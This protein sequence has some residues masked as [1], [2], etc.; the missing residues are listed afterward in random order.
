MNAASWIAFVIFALF[1]ALDWRALIL[2]AWRGVVSPG[3][4]IW[5]ALWTGVAIVTLI[6]G[7]AS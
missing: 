1:A 5:V 3:N 2:N 4:V 7:R 6:V